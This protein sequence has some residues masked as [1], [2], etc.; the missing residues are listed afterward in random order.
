MFSARDYEFLLLL[1][2][3]C[4]LKE[5]GILS[6]LPLIVVFNVISHLTIFFLLL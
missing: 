3:M 6:S 1:K 4:A 5:E 2:N